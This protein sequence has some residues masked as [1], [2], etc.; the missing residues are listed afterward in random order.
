MA[1]SYHEVGVLRTKPG[2]GT[3][4]CSMSCSDK[5]M[6]WNV[7]G[8]QGALMMSF[9]SQ[10]IYI[11]S[12]VTVEHGESVSSLKR[13]LI[14]RVPRKEISSLL[15]ETPYRFNQPN[16]VGTRLWFSYSKTSVQNS[17]PCGSSISW[18][19]VSENNYDVIAKNGLRLGVTKKHRSSPRAVS[20]VSRLELFKLFLQFCE[21]LKIKN[22]HV[23]DKFSKFKTYNEFKRS[24]QYTDVWSEIRN[25]LF[26]H[27]IVHDKSLDSFNT[28]LK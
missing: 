23:H 10:P 15:S 6:K 21:K 8:C 5:M 7:M 19:A 11:S 26:P 2:R 12:F 9:L 22:I 3:P 13:A 20:C 4:T 16:I 18:C 24:M 27:W 17:T 25:I 28:E 14:E 1:A